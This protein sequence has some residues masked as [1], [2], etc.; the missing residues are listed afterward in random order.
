MK[1]ATLRIFL[2]VHTWVGLV[3]G[4]A[5]FIAF[6]AGAITVFTH[7][8]GDWQR[9][10]DTQPVADPIGRSQALLDALLATDPDPELGLFLVLPGAHGPQPSAY[11]YNEAS[12]EQRRFVLDDTDA[13]RE[14]PPRTGFVDFVYDLHFTAG[15]PRVFGSYLF[16]IVCVLYGLAL[17]SGVVIYAPAFVRDLFALRIGRNIKR[18]WQDTHNVIGVL[19]LP[20]H[21]IFAWTGAV[22]TIGLLMLVPFQSLVYEGKLF[23]VLEADYQVTPHVAAA[24]TSRPMLPVAELLQRA[25]ATIP[26]LAVNSVDYRGAGDANARAIVYGDLNQ[27]RL[28]TAG[29]VAMAAA[30]GEVVDSTQPEAYSPGRA[31]LFALYSLH[32]GTFGHEAVKWLYFVLGLAGA[33]LFYGGNLLWIEAR[34]KRRQVEQPRRT[35]FMAALTL[36]VCLGCVAGVSAAFLA[37]ALLPEAWAARCYFIVFFASIAWAFARPPARA[38]HE[39]LWLCALLTLA[40]PVAGAIGSGEHLFAAFANCHWHR[41]SVDAGA[42]VFALAFWRMARATLRRG[43]NGDPNSVWAL[44]ARARDVRIP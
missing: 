43:Y 21:I 9:P 11:L 37:G 6:Y 8:L 23:Q 36:G 2:S 5:L 38:G 34:R 1:T 41:F 28:S 3:A 39:L 33:F 14:T 16:G 19:S 42:L 24:G 17:V 27:R 4:M 13:L 18:L 29:A 22:L 7:E 30:T 20:F 31:F 35:R 12:G 25:Q 44:P 26:G 40:I 10:A 32:F 15:L